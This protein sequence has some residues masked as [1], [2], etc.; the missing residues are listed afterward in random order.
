MARL[1]VL[2]L[3]VSSCVIAFGEANAKAEVSFS[4]SVT[5]LGCIPRRARTVRYVTRDVLRRLY[6]EAVPSSR[7]VSV[8][9][10]HIT[11]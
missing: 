3:V 8:L 10:L 6:Q 9:P 5:D 2:G 11:N 4:V 7:K 1:A